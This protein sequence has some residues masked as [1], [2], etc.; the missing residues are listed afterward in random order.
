SSASRATSQQKTGRIAAV[1]RRVRG[2]V[3]WPHGNVRGALRL[4]S[5]VA[6][7]RSDRR[8]SSLVVY[9]PAWRSQSRV[10]AGAR[11]NG[12][13]RAR[14]CPQPPIRPCARAL[15]GQKCAPCKRLV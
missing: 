9:H 4:Q 8:G 11:R 3:R 14:G 2:G 10:T 13:V 1:L 6:S 7:R 12:A 15:G 5:E